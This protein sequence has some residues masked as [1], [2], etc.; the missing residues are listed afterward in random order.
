MSTNFN[1]QTETL[2]PVKEAKKVLKILY[3]YYIKQAKKPTIDNFYPIDLDKLVSLLGW[4]F[5]RVETAGYFNDGT[6]KDA[7]TKFKDKK[8]II[9]MHDG[10]SKQ[11]IRFSIAHEIGHIRLHSKEKFT[12]LPRPRPL[13]E[14][15][16]HTK[17]NGRYYDVEADRFAT[18]LLMP[19]RAVKYQFEKIF[20]TTEVITNTALARKI[21]KKNKKEFQYREIND[22][23]NLSKIAAT[24]IS[25]DFELQKSLVDFFDVS[26][27]A[28]SNRLIELR[29]ILD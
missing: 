29:L 9:G 23:K 28:M 6:I 12:E 5:E 27:A 8:I 1:F 11:R 4:T 20:N 18:E 16:T 15:R 14:K 13:R 22:K 19:M 25:D 21:T 26:I 24:Y 3:D 17:R 2:K 10:S 7:I